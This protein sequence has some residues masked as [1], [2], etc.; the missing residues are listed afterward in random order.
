MAA[1]DGMRVLDMTQYEAGTSCTQALAWLGAD[2]VKVES[3]EYG[4][5]GRGV[6]RTVNKDY[7][8]Y[9]CAWNSNKRSIALDLKSKEGRDVFMQLVPKFD[10]FVEN[11][12]PGIV[13]KLNI[14]YEEL[15]AVNPGLIY[16]RIKGFGTSGPYSGYRCMDMIAQAAAGAFSITGE[17][18]G[19]PM[20]PGSTTGDSG[21]GVQ[22]AMAILAAYVQ[23][24]RTGEGQEI[25]MSMQEAMIYFVRTRAYIGSEWGTQA[26]GRYGNAGGVPP[27]NIYPCKPFGP[28]DYIYLMPVNE[29]H[30]DSLVAAMERPELLIDKR[31]E[32]SVARVEN[33][34]ALYEEICNWTGQRTKYEAMEAIAGAGVPCSAC[35]DTAEIH[36]DK[37]LVERGFI[38][39]MELPVHGKVPMLGFAPRMSESTVEMKRPPRL[40]EHTDDVLAAELGFEEQQIDNLRRTGIIGDPKRFS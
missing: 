22:A 32:T 23:K 27:V 5:P 31:F 30:W 7:S 40:G 4:D 2:V 21:T 38:H 20:M 25:E 15:S 37:H 14:G 11:Y 39:E 10:V 26:S 33:G 18:D 16:T 13:E 3:P 1:L 34:A 28:N 9:F 8:A 17:A 35:L 24:Q 29:G 12:G 19:P 6:G 36:H